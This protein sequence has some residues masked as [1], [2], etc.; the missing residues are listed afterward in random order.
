MW[1]LPSF[2]FLIAFFHRAAPGVIARELMQEFAATGTVVGLLA[3]TYFY[4]YAGG[5][6]PAGVLIDAYGPRRIVAAGGAVMG[7]G[8][9][10]MALAAAPGPLFAGRL[11]V[12]LGATATFIGAMKIAA[13]WFPPARFGT[14]SALTATVGVLG[15]IVSNAPL[16]ALVAWAGWRGAFALVGVVTLAGALACVLLVRD[17]PSEAGPTGATAPGLRAVLAGT[18]RVLGNPHTWPP[19]LAFFFMYA[20]MG[21]LMLWAVPYLRD[22]YRLGTTE[23]AGYATITAAVLLVSAP[24][25]GWLSDVLGRRKPPYLGLT[26]ASCALWAVQALTAGTLPL[27]GV[28]LLWGLLGL[29]GGAFVLTWPIGREANPPEL[30]G[31]AVAVVNLGGFVGA[32]FTQGVL[33]AVLDA[34]WTGATAGGARVYPTDAYQAAFWVCTGFVAAAAVMAGL[35]RERGPRAAPPA[36]RAA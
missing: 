5:M 30:A 7:A 4:S 32:A 11:V 34:R 26:L 8:T 21:N 22:V 3:A 14:L 23:A 12:G 13:A 6:L 27:A 35:V 25:T 16:A 24:A 19:F 36:G 28:A 29:V 2:L 31:S 1:G 33:G 9:L 20:A 18:G 10:A 17:R 15:S